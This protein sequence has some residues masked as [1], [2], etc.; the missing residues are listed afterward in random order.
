MQVS[1][2]PIQYFFV[3]FLPQTLLFLTALVVGGSFIITVHKIPRAE[4]PCQSSTVIQRNDKK[5]FFQH[6]AMPPESATKLNSVDE[7][8]IDRNTAIDDFSSESILSSA[9]IDELSLEVVTSETID[10][11]FDER[12]SQEKRLPLD[13]FLDALYFSMDEG[14]LLKLTLSENDSTNRDEDNETTNEEMNTID[15]QQVRGWGAI[16]G[17]LIKTK[18]EGGSRLQLISF[19]DKSMKK[20]EQTKNY[21]SSEEL[22][23]IVKIYILNAFQKATLSTKEND[24]EYKLRGKGQGKFRITSK[25]WMQS[26]RIQRLPKYQHRHI[27][28]FCNIFYISYHVYHAHRLYPQIF[29]LVF[30]RL[31]TYFRNLFSFTLFLKGFDQVDAES[32]LEEVITSASDPA[33]IRRICEDRRLLLLSDPSNQKFKIL[34]AEA[35]FRMKSD[36]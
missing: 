23:K 31:S 17:R 28:I 21:S 36:F 8:S 27:H 16:T 25:V 12:F 29:A 5:S 24:Y 33:T 3:M 15:W 7:L 22:I 34:Y 30:L 2:V 35:K 11:L 10:E 1:W 18:L 32:V 6:F 19:K 20:S 9:S 26:L 4:H 13:Q 14:T